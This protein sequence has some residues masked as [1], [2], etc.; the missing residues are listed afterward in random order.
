MAPK[1]L[2]LLGTA[3]AGLLDAG[4]NCGYSVSTRARSFDLAPAISTLLEAENASFTESPR[5]RAF[6]VLCPPPCS[7]SQR[8]RRLALELRH[9]S[10][11]EQPLLLTPPE[12]A[13]ALGIS[14]GR[15]YDLV[16]MGIFPAVRLGKNVRVLRADLEAFLAQGGARLPVVTVEQPRGPR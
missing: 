4:L 12:V 13:S 9:M 7:K 1:G 11:Y 3:A 14:V 6:F 8:H 2:N 5:W 15:L 10:G 16:R